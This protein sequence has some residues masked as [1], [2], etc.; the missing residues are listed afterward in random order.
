MKLAVAYLTSG[1][2]FL[3]LDLVWL[4]LVATRL[5]REQMGPLL[6]QPL[7]MTAA[8][9]FYVLYIAGLLIFAVQPALAEGGVI[10]A[11]MLGAMLGFFSYMTYDLTGLAVIR[12]FP[13]KLAI[14]D[15]AWGT[16]VSALAAAAGTYVAAK[17]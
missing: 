2:V 9:A 12:G 17:L 14:I 6:A 15:I 3:V 10:R 7:N 16:A 1:I 4:G 8:V 11:L 5:Y 13:A